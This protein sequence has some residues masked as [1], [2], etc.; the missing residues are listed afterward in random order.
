[1]TTRPTEHVEREVKLG[2]DASFDL[3]DFAGALDGVAVGAP[4]VSELDAV[5]FDTGDLRLVRAGITVRHRHDG[6]RGEW[7]VKL[8]EGGGTDAAALQRREHTIPAAPGRVGN[9]DDEATFDDGGLQEAARHDG[10]LQDGGLHDGGV[11]AGGLG[12]VPPA[13]DALVRAVVRTAPLIAVA[14]LRTTRRRF[15]LT[16]PDGEPCGELDDDEVAVEVPG[17]SP[18]GT[19]EEAQ[20]RFREIEVEVTERAPAELLDALVTRLRAAG[21]REHDPSPKLARAL[22]PRA[23]APAE[24]IVPM[25]GDGPT[26]AE[27]IGAAL[28]ASVARIIEHD[29]VIRADADPEGVHQARVG[30]RRL[31]SDLRTFR[32]LLDRSWSDPLRE[33]LRWVAG[34]L[35][36][37]RDTDVLLA[38][39]VR[40]IEG[41]PA[42][43]R[44]ASAPLLDALRHQRADA[45]RA[46]VAA[47]DDRRYLE[48]LDRLVDAA[49]EPRLALEAAAPAADVLPR[50]VSSPWRKLRRAIAGLGDEPSDDDLHQVR[51]RAKRARYAADVAR[52]VA[53]KPAA[54]L[55]GALSE[56]QDVLGD[57]HDAV[58]TEAWL[59]A[60]VRSTTAQAALAAGMLVA[61]QRAEAAESRHRW[62]SAWNAARAKK[63]T[64]WLT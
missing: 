64:R 59:R 47:L 29:R 57:V 40:Q 52:P 5:Y 55:A 33:E 13:L 20:S 26:A 46:L 36:T 35:G 48:L 24:L 8:P 50:L 4:V 7:T 15:V 19:A 43:D 63:R 6:S 22:G 51:I 60:A 41:L 11:S 53:G 16:R 3:P 58:V 30:T 32:P 21:A 10:G 9:D 62:P 38:R 42:E 54:K 31:R 14:R 45:Q 39:V 23:S 37:A 25:L 56:L 34:E 49:N 2:A 12:P 44:V 17:H 27:V 1:M 61:C 18:D 28:T